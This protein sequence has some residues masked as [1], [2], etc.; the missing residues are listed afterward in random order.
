[1]K[2]DRHDGRQNIRRAFF[3]AGALLAFSAAAM[4]WTELTALRSERRV[5]QDRM[6]IEQLLEV[7]STVKDAETGERGYLLTGDEGYL[8]P[9]R[10]AKS[11]I[12]SSLDGLRRMAKDGELPEEQVKKVIELAG[13]ELHELEETIGLRRKGMLS[14]AQA[15]A[16]SGRAR[17]IMD[18]MQSSIGSMD[19]REEAECRAAIQGT[20]RAVRRCAAAFIVLGLGNLLFLGWV[21]RR[22]MAEISRRKKAE[23]E[24]GKA[25]HELELRVEERTAELQKAYSRLVIETEQRQKVEEQLRHAQKME[26]V[27]TLAGGIAHGFNNMLA[28]II[29]NTELALDEIRADSLTGQLLQQVLEAS[30]RSRAL[31]RQ[32]LT[33]SRK[34]DSARSAVSLAPLIE[35]TMKLLHGSIPGTVRTELRIEAESDTIRA[36]PSQIQQVLMNLCNNA[37]HA[38]A[39]NGGTLTVRLSNTTVREG[40]PAPDRGMPPGAYAVLTVA[41]TGSGIPEGIR[42]RIF[43]PFFT[44]K[45][46][47]QGTGMGLAVVFGIVKGHE[48]FITV[49][50]EEDKGSVFK[51]F[52]PLFMQAADEESGRASSLPTGNETVL[53]VD[54]EPSVLSMASEILKRLGYH[55][56]AAGGASEAWRTFESDPGLF[57]LVIT[58]HV[59]PEM[60]G[61]TLAGKMLAVRKTCP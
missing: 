49:E 59:M 28:V 44:T 11:R 6:I 14:P 23:E 19:A 37:V 53:L 29:G 13:R 47:G 7:L 39:E 54:D 45:A 51:A 32:I 55:V 20:T 46:T 5:T 41:D 52:F 42:A 2:R 18:E 57:D 33:F 38:M 60:T 27:G 31:V 17:Y 3:V 22:C 30:M 61:I 12:A 15:A 48:G 35:E 34:G 8:V 50:S 36:D 43:D 25:N 58:D 9:Y 16:I 4:Y 56:I 1:M 24:I 21:Y 10:H 40:E 26:A